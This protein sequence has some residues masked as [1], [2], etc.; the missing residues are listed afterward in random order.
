MASHVDDY[1]KHFDPNYELPDPPP[2]QEMSAT[3]RFVFGWAVQVA[4]I[5]MLIFA[6]LNLLLAFANG[7]IAPP[8]GGTI[9]EGLPTI[10]LAT[11]GLG[12]LLAGFGIRRSSLMTAG[13][14][15]LIGLIAGFYC[16][17]MAW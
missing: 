3:T 10:A 7:T 1:S 5:A 9:R 17:P 14:G 2:A 4:G 16:T 15:G 11:A 12:W 6:F 13:V 8:Y